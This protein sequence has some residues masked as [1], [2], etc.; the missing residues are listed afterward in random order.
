MFCLTTNY[1]LEYIETTSKPV[2]IELLNPNRDDSFDKNYMKKF[3][4]SLNKNK[5][6]TKLIMTSG[7]YGKSKNIRYDNFIKFF[8]VPVNIISIEIPEIIMDMSDKIK[9]QSHIVNLKLGCINMIFNMDFSQ[10]IDL[11]TIVI[12]FNYL[13]NIGF[14]EK[15]YD[16]EN[17]E[18]EF[19]RFHDN[20]IDI[21]HLYQLKQFGFLKYEKCE[22]I[23][24]KLMKNIKLPYGCKI[25]FIDE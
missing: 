17:E 22:D 3:F 2:E 11:Q 15:V 20:P 8:K 6:S 9:L 25:I 1:M 12:V 13:N 18:S 7:L 24:G 21:S 10:N 23:I 5:N 14:V 16:E 4:N 19:D